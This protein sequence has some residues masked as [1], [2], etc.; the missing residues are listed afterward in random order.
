MA[1]LL[2]RY[3]AWPPWAR[4]SGPLTQE[5]ACRIWTASGFQV[6]QQILYLVG[7]FRLEQTAGFALPGGKVM[8]GKRFFDAGQGRR[9][10]AQL[11]DAQANQ[12]R[13]IAYISGDLST[14]GD[15]TLVDPG[16]LDDV[17]DCAPEGG[18]Q[19]GKETHD[20]AVGP[21]RSQGVLKKIVGS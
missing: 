4:N 9:A 2:R 5:N 12:Q 7:S 19:A 14:D 17:I 3:F 10:N 16:S 18:L 1:L 8:P 20:A 15:G 6:G 11:L 13:P 21:I